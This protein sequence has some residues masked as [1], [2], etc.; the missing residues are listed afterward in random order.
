MDVY[1]REPYL[2]DF[3]VVVDALE[4]VEEP[5][6]DLREL[7]DPVHPPVLLHRRRQLFSGAGLDRRR[8]FRVQG[9]GFRVQGSGFRAQAAV[10][11]NR[12]QL[13]RVQLYLKDIAR[14]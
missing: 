1:E 5:L 12:E 8:V 9:A 2:E 7:V 4:A 10:Q 14:A 11:R 6:V 3:V 13:S